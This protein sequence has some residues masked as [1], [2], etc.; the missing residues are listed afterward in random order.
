MAAPTV[1]F[2]LDGKTLEVPAGITIYDAAR[3]HGVDIPILCHK[4]DSK[5]EFKSVGVCRV[6]CV[7]EGSPRLPDQVPKRFIAACCRK[8]EEGMTILTEPE[9]VRTARETLI[10]LLL[11]EHPVPCP[12]H[13]AFH[14]CELE[15]LGEKY[16]LLRTELNPEVPDATPGRYI[17]KWV[18]PA[19]YSARAFDKGTDTTN[20]SIRVDHGSCILCDRCVRACNDVA[21]HFVIGREGKGVR[22]AITFDDGQTMGR[23]TCVN[24]GWCMVACPTGALTYGGVGGRPEPE[25]IQAGKDGALSASDM[26]A[27]E[28]W[29][30]VSI[31]F[32]RRAEGGVVERHFAPGDIICRQGEFG[33]TAFYI[34]SGEVEIYL[35]DAQG[36]VR[37]KTNKGLVK[38]V[39]SLLFNKQGDQ[40]RRGEDRR[41]FIPIDAGVDLDAQKPIATL[42]AG[43]LF[44]EA[45][46]I[47]NQPRSATIRAT[48]PTI[49]LEMLRNVLDILRR[50]KRF[51]ERSDERY[52]KYA[53][54][55]HLRTSELFQDVPP[56]VVE[57][58][59]KR[60]SLLSYEPGD[61]IFKQGDA[62][63]ALYLVRLGHVRVVETYGDGGSVTLAYLSRGEV[64]GEIGLIG[65]AGN[66]RT[67][68]CAAL[69]HVELVRVDRE[70]FELLR[71]QH[72]P[73]DERVRA[74]GQGR[75]QA[76]RERAGRQRS[77][78]LQQYVEQGLYEAQSLLVLDLE[79]C[80]RCD[81]CV[82]AC[83][84]AHNGV[85]RLLRE[86]LR[87]DK[88]L[89]TTSCRSCRDPMCMIGCPV[90]AIHRKSDKEILIADHCVGCGLC[91]DQCPY[92]NIAMHPFNVK[93]E[94]SLAK[95]KGPGFKAT[96][97]DLCTDQCLD[98][99]EEPSCVY[100]CPHDAASRVSGTELFDR[101]LGPTQAAKIKAMVP[102]G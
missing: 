34:D 24:C 40:R 81:E 21:E 51:R 18:K 10:E 95:G 75:L 20:E 33:S 7:M 44:G 13:S 48:K 25:A 59:R 46:C 71:K 58:L 76:N 82:R 42:G 77:V 66:V 60:V 36:H 68:T 79:R 88:Y 86:G 96:V 94:E 100:A 43:E 63:D 11:S 15:L 6:C 4:E 38:R 57:H 93:D 1:K 78:S 30:D 69:D 98:E 53:L 55:N 41:S 65:T 91:A 26:K 73:L 23:S 29:R 87:F 49:V 47:N 35:E 45:S 61:V 16:G 50:Q 90:G 9:P 64:F 14:T 37:T 80:T 70:D 2:E 19:V 83:A 84:E 62:A 97:C 12:K 39:T 5:D 72:P 17:T 28:L 56:D 31:E 27:H 101:I 3:L 74:I 102:K 85:S 67:A 89:V 8:V 54:D 22:S 32:L 99:D 92:G 52:R